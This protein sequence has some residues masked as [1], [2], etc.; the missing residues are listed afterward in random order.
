MSILSTLRRTYFELPL[1][2]TFIKQVINKFV[3]E[4]YSYKYSSSVNTTGTE[5]HYTKG[6]ISIAPVGSS[7]LFETY[8]KNARNHIFNFLGSGWIS[9]DFVGRDTATKQI[10]WHRDF[11]S[12]YAFD[13]KKLYKQL[14]GEDFPPG[15]DVKVPWELA[16]MQHLPMLAYQSVIDSSTKEDNYAEFKFEIESFIKSNRIGEGINWACTMDVALRVV[17][18]LIAAD[19]FNSIGLS[20]ESFNRLLVNSSVEHGLFIINNLE[21]NFVEDKSGNHYLSDLLGL[22]CVGHYIKNR[23]TNKWFKFASNEY[24]REILKQYYPDG[25][26]Y[27]FSTAYHRLDSEISSLAIAFMVADGIQIGTEQES[28]LSRSLDFLL[29]IVGRDGNIIQI[30]DND[31]GHA[32]SVSVE[33]NRGVKNELS[34][35]GAIGLLEGLFNISGNSIAE[36]SI[37]AFLKGPSSLHYVKE[38]KKWDNDYGCMQE[39]TIVCSKINVGFGDSYRLASFFPDFG[40][41]KYSGDKYDVYYRGALNY[42][43][44]KVTHMHADA[45]HFEIVSDMNRYYSDQG[46][47]LYTPNVEMRSL[48]RREQAHNVPVYE[49]NPQ[50]IDKGCWRVIPKARCNFLFVDDSKVVSVMRIGDIVHKRSL[51][52]TTE[53]IIVN[54]SSSNAFSY[55]PHNFKYTSFGYGQIIN[56]G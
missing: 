44:G 2:K 34:A 25:G 11:V 3:P 17:S 47:Y 36:K 12:N 41:I 32:L 52:L 35:Y 48:F 22:I 23:Q 45:L 24:Q 49:D 51:S 13:P 39:C 28:K 46:S 27:E 10:D 18:W 38:K 6:S 8:C 55:K 14:S 40:L 37:I 50:L 33:N 16:R 30:G 26:T 5:L 9:V 53:G 42:I 19:I 1:L 54:D 15:V 4:L 21:K 29:A 43:N 7:L 20:D 31:N 56:N